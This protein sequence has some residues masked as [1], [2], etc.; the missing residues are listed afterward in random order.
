MKVVKLMAFLVI[1]MGFSCQNSTERFGKAY[2]DA[3]TLSVKPPP[4]ASNPVFNAYAQGYLNLWNSSTVWSYSET[5]R[6]V[7]FL[8]NNRGRFESVEQSTGVPWFVV[9]II[10]LLESGGNFRTHLHNGDSL[11]GRTYRVPAGRP[12]FGSPPFTWEESAIDALIYEGLDRWNPSQWYRPEVIAYALEAYNG[13]GYRSKGI[14]SPYLWSKTNHYVR[15]K[16]TYDGYYDPYAVSQQVGGMAILKVG[17]LEGVWSL[18]GSEDISIAGDFCSLT[19]NARLYKENRGDSPYYIGREGGRFQVLKTTGNQNWYQIQLSPSY[20]QSK[21]KVKNFFG[22]ERRAWVRSQDI[23][24]DEYVTHQYCPV[25]SMGGELIKI[26]DKASPS[27]NV[28]LNLEQ[29]A[30]VAVLDHKQHWAK[31]TFVLNGTTYGKSSD[32]WIYKGQLDC[33]GND[34]FASSHVSCESSKGSASATFVRSEP[35]PSAPI[36]ASLEDGEL[37]HAFARKDNYIAV[38]DSNKSYGVNKAKAAYIYI[39]QLQCDTELEQSFEFGAHITQ[40]HKAL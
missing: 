2:D 24:C 13:F 23:S 28:L 26:R 32:V 9:G 35:N 6:Q 34:V 27:G 25:V 30:R 19:G 10:S 17:I 38:N 11:N 12:K 39:G 37:L 5:L 1:A 22:S 8:E 15:G 33:G 29:N 16:Y 3:S 14:N 4:T 18:D 31:V 40:S 7:R 36:I 21:S 20:N